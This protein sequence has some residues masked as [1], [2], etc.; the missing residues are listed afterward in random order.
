MNKLKQQIIFIAQLG[1]KK[2]FDDL[3]QKGVDVNAADEYG[4]TPLH[5]A[6]LNRNYKSNPSK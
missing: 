4:E 5:Y 1:A 2:I 6:A 3:I